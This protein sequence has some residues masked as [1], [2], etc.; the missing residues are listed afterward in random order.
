MKVTPW[1]EVPTGSGLE[2]MVKTKLP[3]TLAAP[4]DNVL[5]INVCP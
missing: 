4:P 1:L 5:D 3:G 2:D